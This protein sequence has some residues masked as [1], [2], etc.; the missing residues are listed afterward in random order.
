MMF[1]TVIV[2]LAS[3]FAVS[4]CAPIG[5]SNCGNPRLVKRQMGVAV[6]L[7]EAAAPVVVSAMLPSVFKGVKSFGAKM[8]RKKS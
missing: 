6:K 8:F 5:T 3:M 7:A 1:T 4:H 2:V